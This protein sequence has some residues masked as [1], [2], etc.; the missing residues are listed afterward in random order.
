MKV[1]FQLK[2]AYDDL[3]NSHLHKNLEPYINEI[4]I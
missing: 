2:N 1:Q 3:N 4:S